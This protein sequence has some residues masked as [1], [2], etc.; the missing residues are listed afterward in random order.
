MLYFL[1]SLIEDKSLSVEQIRKSF[2]E[3]NGL[4]L[5]HDIKLSPHTL[6]SIWEV[7]VNRASGK[8]QKKIASKS[9]GRKEKYGHCGVEHD[10]GTMELYTKDGRCISDMTQKEIDEYE[11]D[12]RRAN[13]GDRP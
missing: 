13:F 2:L 7:A 8:T 12:R 5:C 6:N 10:I 3:H 1:E 4:G 9:Y 11:E